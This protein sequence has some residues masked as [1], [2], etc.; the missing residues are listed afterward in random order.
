MLYISIAA[1]NLVQNP[2]TYIRIYANMRQF[3]LLKA[4]NIL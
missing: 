1:T 4:L 2:T 3:K